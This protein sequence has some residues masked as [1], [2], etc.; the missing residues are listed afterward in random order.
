M[1]TGI[2]YFPHPSIIWASAGDVIFGLKSGSA[3]RAKED[4]LIEPSDA[5]LGGHGSNAQIENAIVFLGEEEF[6]IRQ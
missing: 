3:E 5:L 4:G 1:L 2:L 6:T